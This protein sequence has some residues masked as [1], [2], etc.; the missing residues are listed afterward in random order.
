MAELA[1]IV[2][3]RLQQW[4]TDLLAAAG[5]PRPDAEEVA[6]HL[7]FADLR[8]I[9]T[10]GTSRLKIYLA[11]MESGAMSR[12]TNPRVLRETPVSALVDGG[13]GLGQVVSR[14]AAD[15][16]ITKARTS[17]MAAVAVRNSNHC[18]CMAYYTMLMA[19][20]GLIGLASTNSSA[21]M[22]PF[23]GKAAYF[24]TNPFS[25][26]AP[27]GEHRPFVFDMATSQV[28]RGKIINAAREGKSIPEGW[29]ITREGVPT[30]DAREGLAGF[31][32]P[33]AGAKGSAL[34]FMVEILSGVLPGALVG[35][36]LPRMY[37]D[38][39]QPQQ[40]GHFFM[41]FQPDL[42]M[43]ADEFRARMDRILT[44]VRAVPPAPGFGQV[45]APGDVELAKEAEFRRVG[46]PI[47]P[48]V[49]GEFRELAARYGVAL[50]A[51]LA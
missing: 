46:V 32:V 39:S 28:A 43:A 50:P 20:A 48:G 44:E 49:H 19:E 23:G 18:G 4:S 26:A 16:A 29:A 12:T 10:H 42:F 13:N 25:L 37:E 11:R 51:E 38:L 33:M 40:V 36:A 14:F 17:G 1:R 5:V 21:N 22:P 31:V 9:D 47:P 3:Q 41:A 15:L 6:R 34:A 35:P 2:P 8:G 7:L 24:G 45:M 30:T 27:A